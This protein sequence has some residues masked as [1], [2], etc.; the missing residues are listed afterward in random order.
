[1]ETVVND[2]KIWDEIYVKE[3]FNPGWGTPGLDPNIVN[4][5]K[6]FCENN[7]VDSLTLLDVGCGNGRNSLVV[8]ELLKDG[9]KIEYTG[10]DFSSKA[11]DYCKE[12]Y[13]NKKFMG[14]DIT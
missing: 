12:T 2:K 1:M 9:I 5:I 11:I 4:W 8:E 7:D 10:I 3:N 6:D 14:I 13:K